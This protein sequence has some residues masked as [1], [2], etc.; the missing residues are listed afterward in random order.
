MTRKEAKRLKEIY[1]C[2]K[3]A[4]LEIDKATD[5][6]EADI[7]F[8]FGTSAYPTWAPED[9]IHYGASGEIIDIQLNDNGDIYF[10]SDRWMNIFGKQI[11]GVFISE[12]TKVEEKTIKPVYLGWAHKKLQWCA[13][14]GWLNSAYHSEIDRPSE[15]AEAVLHYIIDNFCTEYVDEKVFLLAQERSKKEF[16]LSLKAEENYYISKNPEKQ[17]K[18][19]EDGMMATYTY[20]MIDPEEEGE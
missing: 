1:K 16:G 19:S 11:Y 20:S 15:I 6:R 12:P 17:G 3:N 18:I 4:Y 13:A 8:V 14:I 2:I 10:T 5:D 9:H 7:E